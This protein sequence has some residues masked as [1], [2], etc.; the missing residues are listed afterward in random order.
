MVEC[1][2]QMCQRTKGGVFNESKA[3]DGARTG[4]D[5]HD[6]SWNEN[7]E[8]RLRGE[9]GNEFPIIG[10]SADSRRHLILTQ[11]VKM[12]FT[13]PS[14]VC[15]KLPLSTG[16]GAEGSPADPKCSGKEGSMEKHS[17]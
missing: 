8:N 13:D 16:T 14:A 10:L 12:G 1:A 7:N 9:D 2:H 15:A 6:E 4:H 3:A 5:Q 17:Q 11:T